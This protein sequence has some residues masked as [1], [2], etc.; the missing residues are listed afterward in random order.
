MRAFDYL[1][2]IINTAEY[3]G[4]YSWEFVQ[5]QLKK[6]GQEGW[7]L[8]NMTPDWI[9]SSYAVDIP[10]SEIVVWYCTFKRSLS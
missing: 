7:E 9:E 5:K 8:V 1:H 4:P 3:G 2:I 10:Y 6:L